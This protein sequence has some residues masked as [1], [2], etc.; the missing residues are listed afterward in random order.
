MNC[1]CPPSCAIPGSKLTRVRVLVKKN[2]IASTL[3]RSNACGSPRARLRLRSNA[4]SKIVLTSSSVHS[5]GVIMSRP[6]KCVCM[7]LFLVSLFQ[8]RRQKRIEL[9]RTDYIFQRHLIKGAVGRSFIAGGKADRRNSGFPVP[10]NA[11][12]REIPL[13]GWSGLVP[14]YPARFQARLHQRVILV[15]RPGGEILL[16]G[17]LIPGVAGGVVVQNFHANRFRMLLGDERLHLLHGKLFALAEGQAAVNVDGALV[18]NSVNRWRLAFDLADGDPP[19][20][21]ERVGVELVVQI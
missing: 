5:S 15:N 10:V 20:P 6:I 19:L 14:Q 1:A 13:P 11:V 8:E 16:D 9:G 3:S 18:G 7:S 4:T 2:S 21:Q 12:G 17:I